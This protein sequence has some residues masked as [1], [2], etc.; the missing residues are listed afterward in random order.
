MSEM[1]IK[2]L[3][4][5]FFA[6]VASVGFAMVFNVPKHTLVYCAVGGAITFIARSS[7]LHLGIGIEIS[8][9]KCNYDFKS[10]S[11]KWYKFNPKY[12][13]CFK[14]T[15]TSTWIFICELIFR[16]FKRLFDD[17][18]GAMDGGNT[19]NNCHI[20]WNYY[21]YVYFKHKGVVK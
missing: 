2:M 16:L 4:E 11:T 18:L 17:G 5:A 8:I 14:C 21:C 12:C 13:P 1:I 6:S 9:P 20:Y 10:F 3:I 15:I 7:L 19:S